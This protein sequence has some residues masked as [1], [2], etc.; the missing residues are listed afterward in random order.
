MKTLTLLA[1]FSLLA[2]MQDTFA[3]AAQTGAT[4]VPSTIDTLAWLQQGVLADDGAWDDRFGTAVAVDGNVAV[5][6]A[7]DA[8]VGD[9]Y[10]QGAAYVFV[11]QDGVWTQVQKLLADDGAGMANFGTA[12]AVA[13]GTILVSAIG[14]NVDGSSN[15]GAVYVFG[16][17]GGSWTQSQRL[18]ADDG[19]SGDAFG[20]AIAL[21]G[22]VALIAAKGATVNG[23]TLQG[24]V[25]VFVTSGDEWAQQQTLVAPDGAGNDLFGQ[26]VALDGDIAL[27]GAPTFTYNFQHNGWVYAYANVGGTWEQTQKIVPNDSTQGDQFGY[28]VGLSGDTAL[29]S[30][31]GNQFSHGAAYVFENDAGTWTQM[32]R[33]SPADSAS[34]DEFGNA[35]ALSGTT[36]IIGAE[37][38]V[39]DGHQGAAYVF[40]E[41]GGI[42][43][44]SDEFT[45]SAGTS[46]DFFGGA[47][48]FDGSTA[49]IGIPGATIESAQFQGAASFYAHSGT[50]VV[51]V[52]PASVVAAQAAD[53]TTRQVL[54][55]ANAGD[56]DL[57]WSIAE[58]AATCSTPAELPWLSADP[59]VGSTVASGSTDVSVTF[60]SSGLAPGEYDGVLCIDSNDPAQGMLAVPVSLTVHVADGVFCSGFED[61]KD[62]SCTA[63]APRE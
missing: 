13:G 45:E 29:I 37:R 49:L 36:A 41:S 52:A 32:Q 21:E 28:A 60:D 2:C 42:W 55:I 33:M 23:N 10:D 18:V 35:L 16:Q 43:G 53:T 54:T 17:V 58:A 26:S 27:V 30:T 62:G 6:G 25:Y 47:V 40:S 63:A 3:T 39:L 12:V 50:A 24:K 56:G 44:Q 34:G 59:T 57:V 51:G 19:G 61:G 4:R 7:A 8:K 1:S 9:N 46:L 31:T 15:Q 38:I 5:I 14:A 11:R 48:A 20:N 22:S